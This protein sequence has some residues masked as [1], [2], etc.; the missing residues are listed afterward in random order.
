LSG[1]ELVD[2]IK[3]NGG[4]LIDFLLIGFT[5]FF[6]YG[7]QML[8]G[9]VCAV[10]SSSKKVASAATGFTGTFGYIGAMLSGIGTGII[11]DNFGWNGAL[12]FWGL[13]ALICGAI[14]LPMCR[15]KSAEN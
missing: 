5:G 3:I 7:P 15:K 12:L 14:I 11:V 4:S 9:G 2:V 13:S 8:I 1:Y 6:T 10:E